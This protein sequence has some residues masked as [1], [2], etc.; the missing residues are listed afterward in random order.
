MKRIGWCPFGVP[1][2]IRMI[3]QRAATSMAVSWYT[4]TTPLRLRL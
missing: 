2:T 4:L 3:A 1:A